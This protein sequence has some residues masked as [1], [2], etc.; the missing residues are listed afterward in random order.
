VQGLVGFFV[1]QKTTYEIVVRLV[2]S[3]MC[4]RERLRAALDRLAEIWGIETP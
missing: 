1:K 2:G 4:I 3:E